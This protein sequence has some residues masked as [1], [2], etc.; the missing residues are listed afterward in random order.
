MNGLLASAPRPVVPVD[1]RRTIA[2]DLREA[3]A[4]IPCLVAVGVLLALARDNGQAL[5]E[6]AP[7]GLA[8]LALLAVTARALPG[9]WR[10]APGAIRAAV[11]LLGAFTA[12][13]ALSIF[14]ADDRGAAWQGADRML[15][16]LLVFS[17]FALW[18]QRSRTAAWIL[19]G[20]TL[21]VMALCLVALLR[22]GADPVGTLIDGRLD[23]P[24]G[25][26]NAAAASWLMALLPALTLAAS[27]RVHWA[28][29]GVFAAGVVLL[30]DVALL[31]QSR[32][33]VLALPVAIALFLL[34]VPGRLRHFWTL[35]PVA[36]AAAVVAPKVLDA[37]HA[38]GADGAGAAGE[39]TS[40]TRM[41]VLLALG[42]GLVI[43]AAAAYEH[44]R[45]PAEP[46]ARTIRRAATIAAVV[47]VVAGALGVISIAGN[48]AQRVSN[49]WASFKGATYEDVDPA[50]RLGSG[51]GSNRYDFYRVALDVFAAH[52]VVGVGA[53]NYAQDY[54]ADARSHE[55]PTYPHSLELAVLSETGV[56]GAFLLGGAL[57]AALA[58]AWRGAR[59]GP[60]AAT[61]A[62]GALGA[63]GYWLIHG[64]GDWFFEWAGLGAPAFAFLGLAC[65][66]A[67]RRSAA[68]PEEREGA[69]S[70][71]QAAAGLGARRVRAHGP[72]TALG[73][74][75]TVALASALAAPWLAER[76]VTRA[77][78]LFARRPLQAYDILDRA[79]RLN[80]LSD[81]PALVAGS[82]ALRFVD[83]PRADRAFRE[84]LERNPR[85]SYAT[86]QLGA[87]ASALGDR[88]RALVLLRRASALAP[89][90]PLALEA[91]AVVR[92]GGTIDL[93]ELS[94]RVLQDARSVSGG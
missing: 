45:P 4:T 29:R 66:L 61:V 25:Y 1:R 15:L 36:L 91:L 31:S 7:A 39:L 27:A 64:S 89:R 60:F 52:P 19:G 62:G 42:V 55:T 5:T 70:G 83:L 72:A 93:A 18:P 65:A 48:P 59:A 46:V 76:D 3:P 40:M 88:R 57:L 75:A 33:A 51:L 54:L 68:R 26:P 56:V 63:F 81:R 90:D 9:A 43:A 6:W 73:A 94:R 80:P 24:A 34:I 58:A 16:Y 38:V 21:C 77:A 11:V 28:L 41:V 87:I 44:Y 10:S 12:W 32:G 35:L 17:L 37:A 47:T 84:A 50:N 22:A 78:E 92:R 30:L 49:A 20:W 74:A 14:W 86:L 69:K 85:G 67:P 82:I 79:G 8:M 13:S 23:E 71:D 53:D 2:D